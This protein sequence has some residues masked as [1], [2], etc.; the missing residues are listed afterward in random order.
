[1][2]SNGLYQINVV[3]PPLPDGDHEIVAQAGGVRTVAGT[4]VNVQR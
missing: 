2:V 3:V 1:M 4:Y